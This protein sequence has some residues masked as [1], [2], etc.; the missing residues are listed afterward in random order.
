MG[1][2]MEQY[3]PSA[4]RFRPQMFADVVDQEPVVSTLKNA[5][6]LGRI[7]HAYLFS[8]PRGTGK[9][10]LARLLA[11]ALNCAAPVECEPCNSCTSC[12]EITGG[13]SLDVL[14]IDGASHRGI[15]DVRELTEGVGYASAGGKSKIYI[16]DEV[17]MLTKEAFNALLKTLEEPPEN[18]RFFFATTEA[19]K[20]PATIVSRCQRFELGR[21]TEA[22]IISKL[23]GEAEKLGLEISDGALHLIAGAAEGALRDAESLFDQVSSFCEGAIDEQAASDVLG[24]MPRESLFRLD[25][26]TQEGSLPEALDVAEELFAKGKNLAHFLE[27]MLIHYR[28]HLAAL[29]GQERDPHYIEMCK[30]WNQEQLLELLGHILDAQLKMREAPS[31]RIALEMLLARVVQSRSRFSLEEI[32]GRLEKLQ[33]SEP[34]K[35]EPTKVE[36][37][38]AEPPK[39][40]QAD[41]KG[42]A[43]EE[44]LMRFAA[45]ELEGVLKRG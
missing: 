39:K 30:V 34:I 27:Q 15:D 37:P 17:H 18:V 26:A 44:T 40:P 32:V 2:Y 3:Q 43:R 29:L 21:I 10:T 24:L 11:K 14:E 28:R 35:L 36:P 41:R 5:L 13:H 33:A 19:H 4:R 25:R 9:T 22:S 6:R 42:K 8:G 20:L 23:K 12:Q 38:K 7:S 1:T 31:P 45:V 16:I